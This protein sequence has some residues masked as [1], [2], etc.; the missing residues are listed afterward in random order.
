M[1]GNIASLSGQLDGIGRTAYGASKAALE[2]LTKVMSVELAVHGITVNN[3]APGAIST[4]MAVQMHDRATREAYQ[5]LIPQRRYG[6]LQEIAS[7]VAKLAN[8]G[9]PNLRY[10]A[11]RRWCSRTSSATI[12]PSRPRLACS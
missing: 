10:D 9:C 4:K 3:V 11:E 1:W 12:A 2:L 6:T 8:E 5:Y 7:A